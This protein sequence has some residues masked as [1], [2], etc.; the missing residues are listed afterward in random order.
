MRADRDRII[1]FARELIATNSE[2]PPGHEAE[3]AKLLREHLEGYGLACK[4]VGSSNRPNLIFY[5]HEGE[6][7]PL[8]IHGHMDTVPV[9]DIKDWDYDPFA[10]EIH[11]GRLYGR[12]ACDMKGP[13]AALAETMIQ[14]VEEHPK[15]PLVMLATSDEE[16]GCSGAEAVAK[17]GLLEGIPFGVCAEPTDLKVL[18]GEKGMLWTRVVA[19]GKAAHGSRPEEGLNAITLCTD[20]LRVL[21]ATPY[22]FED[23][24]LMGAPTINVGMI[25]GGVKINVVPDSCQAQIDMRL[26]KGQDIEGTLAEMR[27]RLTE[28]GLSD[29]VSVEYLHGKPAVITPSDAP[30]VDAALGALERVVGSRPQITAATYGTDCSVLQPKIGIVNVILGP[31]SIEQAHQ[32]NEFILVDQLLQA[33]DVYLDTVHNIAKNTI[34]SGT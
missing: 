4:S 6:T 20:A 10:G 5:T 3:V 24:E 15:V 31:G 33:V 9:G 17:S 29:H 12:G 32:P 22:P 18:V 8:V 21:T 25:E 14:Y 23:T 2:N 13:V 1:A 7:G 19:R 28:A 26:V 16:S 27:R 34:V 11:N 30:I